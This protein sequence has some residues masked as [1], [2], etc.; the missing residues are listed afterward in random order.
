MLRQINIVLVQVV[1][2]KETTV[3]AILLVDVQNIFNGITRL[4]PNKVLNYVELIRRYSEGCGLDIYARIAYG[5]QPEEHVPNFAT[6]LRRNG[7]ELNFSKTPHNIEM[8]LKASDLIN[9]AKV[10]A[11]ILGTSYPEAGRILKYAKERG[12]TTYAFGCGMLRFFQDLAAVWEL[13]T[14]EEGE[15]PVLIEKKKEAVEPVVN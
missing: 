13:G 8:A 10:D 15:A 11:I 9:R 14:E 3:K 2:F 4:H 6:M 5:Q 7:F 12:I 1:Q